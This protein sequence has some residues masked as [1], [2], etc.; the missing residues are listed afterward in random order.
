M[1]TRANIKTIGIATLI[2]ILLLAATVLCCLR[3]QAWFGNPPEPPYVAGD[4]I[5]RV[6]LTFGRAGAQSRAVSWQCGDTI[7]PAELHLTNEQQADTQRITAK[8]RLFITAGGQTAYYFADMGLLPAGDYTYRVQVGLQRS[9]WQRFTVRP[10][11][12]ATTTFVYVGDVQDADGCKLHTRFAEI[13]QQFA[14][15]FWLFGGDVIERPHDGYWQAYYDMVADFGTSTPVLTVPGNHEYLKGLDKRLD[16]R[17]VWTFPYFLDADT[18]FAGIAQYTFSVG[19]AAFYLLDS[20]NDV[21][22]LPG[23]RAWLQRA[24]AT[25]TAV[26]HIAT[27]HHPV[28]SLRGRLTNFWVRQAFASLFNDKC[29]LV[30]SG[31]EHAYARR[32]TNGTTPVYLVSQCSPKDYRINLDADYDRYGIGCRFYQVVHMAGDTLQLSAYTLDHVLYDQL[33]L[34]KTDGGTV[35]HDTFTNAPEYLQVDSTR[36]RKS[37]DKRAAYQQCILQR[38]NSHPAP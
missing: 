11:T 37:A 16:E 33:T 10:T 15:D 4:S 8:S 22:T 17:F 27:L 29:D 31:H 38:R 7:Q 36:Y 26:W 28:Y 24:M 1:K 34:L 3:W 14:P 32:A 5:C 20:N 35:L 23:E 25:D 9:A 13:N 21:W 30:L 6:Q 12:D 18:R 19:N 2:G